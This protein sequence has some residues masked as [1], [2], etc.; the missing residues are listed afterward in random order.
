MQTSLA[1]LAPM[2]V[3]SR[4]NGARID[5]RSGSVMRSSSSVSSDLSIDG[6][7]IGE[8]LG[9]GG[10]GRVYRAKSPAGDLVALKLLAPDAE[11]DDVRARDR[12]RREI[13]ALASVRHPRVVELLAHGEDEELGP[14]LVTP[15][16]VGKTLR[17]VLATWRP[18]PPA[19]I[20][21]ITALAGATAAVHAAGL[22]HRDL[23]PENV[24]C[25]DD[26]R[27]V[28]IDLGLALG[29]GHTRYTEEGAVAG[30]AP[31][32]S[33]EQIEGLEV[34]AAADV[35]ALGVML[36]ELV[37]GERP[38][39]RTSVR[40][41]VAAILAG[42]APRM[43]R[44]E[45]R[46]GRELADIGAR[47]LAA[48][49]AQRFA[50]AAELATALSA[51]VAVDDA[52][53]SRLVGEDRAAAE[54]ELVAREVEGLE[55]KAK[56][57]SDPF[58]R[59]R[60]IDQALAYRPGDPSFAELAAALAKP[61]RRRVWWIVRLVA[62]LFIPIVVV[63]IVFGRSENKTT[64][65]RDAPVAMV[66]LDAPTTP[67][68]DPSGVI[69]L[70]TWTGLPSDAFPEGDA[71]I[72][73]KLLDATKV[74]AGAPAP[75]QARRWVECEAA[76]TRE[77]AA[78]PNDTETLLARGR[79]RYRL[80]KLRVAHDDLLAGL[81]RNPGD[82]D[83]AHELAHLA[84]YLGRT[85]DARRVLSAIARARPGDANSWLDLAQTQPE[86]DAIAS[87]DRAAELAPKDPRVVETRCVMFT[88]YTRENAVDVCRV[89]TTIAPSSQKA[90]AQFA[91]A[92]KRSG[93]N[94]E[95]LVAIDR[96]LALRPEDPLALA[97]RGAILEALGRA[98][99][100]L[101]A[102]RRA[103][104]LGHSAA[105]SKLGPKAEH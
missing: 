66:P 21:I 87:L 83:I 92:L 103:C 34:T 35:W 16:L 61:R 68:V 44:V 36:H 32:M 74:H 60:A 105:C 52:L 3:N 8:R 7:V 96:A 9:A 104:R 81:H 49:P 5:V 65:P 99:A 98:E 55:R 11:H 10:S 82:L 39:A 79:L 22:V 2:L 24:I 58:V 80:G 76:F 23:K 73:Q 93:A 63:G 30:S 102:F 62:L 15:L 54:A 67:P 29:A 64:P 50:T 42:G 18:S 72:D 46:V 94:D 38:F 59:V 27:L 47:C 12:L 75:C 101:D 14:Y 71:P 19:A 6:Y 51:L 90:W 13:K 86:E 97:N 4:I 95:A 17:E 37:V 41:E 40:E 77:L 88:Y 31:Y 53:L 84:D 25:T 100:A 89:A 70:A 48:E 20:A 69:D 1:A 45:R 78:N 43:D 56:S 85:D 33:P 91:V 26:G 28:L 57:A